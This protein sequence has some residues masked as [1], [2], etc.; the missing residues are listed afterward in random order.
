MLKRIN[1]PVCHRDN[2][3]NDELIVRDFEGMAEIVPYKKYHVFRCNSCGMVYAGD[4]EESMTLENYYNIMSKYEGDNFRVAPPILR[5]YH[6]VANFI[7]QNISKDKSILDVGCAFGGLLDVLRQRGYKRLNGIEPSPDNCEYAMRN[8]G[9]KVYCGFF[10]SGQRFTDEKA[11]YDLVIMSAVLEH[12]ENLK[13]YVDEAKELLTPNGKICII[14]PDANLFVDNNDLY[15]EFSTEHINYF[16][17]DTLNQLFARAEMECV[18]SI[19]DKEVLHGLAGNIISLFAI[20]RNLSLPIVDKSVNLD[21]YLEQ[22]ANLAEK[23]RN[24]LDEENFERGMYLWCAGTM[25]AMLFQLGIVNNRTVKKIVDSNKN[26]QGHRIFG[27]IIEPPEVLIEE[28]NLPIVI[29]SQYAQESI[30]DQIKK[31]KLPNVVVKL[32]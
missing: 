29:A 6:R 26:Y 10:G 15:Q 18:C 13:S 17:K 19:Q 30:S 2:R 12:I 32:F 4:M 8:F 21:Y 31:W 7:E 3:D 22:C 27:Y 9:I 24:I 16:T 5:F 20:K 23:I 25:T 14:V 1:C 11:K 28:Q